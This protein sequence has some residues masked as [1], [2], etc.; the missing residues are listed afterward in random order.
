[1]AT[2]D[3][4]YSNKDDNSTEE[5]QFQKFT[6]ES[7][8]KDGTDT[9]FTSFP[10]PS[11]DSFEE[12]ADLLSGEKKGPPSFWTWEYYQ[13]LFDVDTNQVLQRILWSMIPRPGYMQRCIKSR[14]DLYGPF[15]I[16]A[17]LVFTIAISGNIADYLRSEGMKK[18]IWRYDFH[19]VSF[20]A[21]AIYTYAWFVPLAIW[22]LLWYRSSRTS[23]SLMQIICVYGYSLSIYIPLSILW[24]ININWLQ[25]SLVLIGSVSSGIVLLLTF[26]PTVKSDEKKKGW[27]CNHWGNIHSS[28]C[29]SS[30]IHVLR[31]ENLWKEEQCLTYFFHGTTHKSDLNNIPVSASVNTARI[32][33]NDTR[34]LPKV[35]S[36]VIPDPSKLVASSNVFKD[37]LKN[38]PTAPT[39]LQKVSATSVPQQALASNPE[40]DS[41]APNLQQ[42]SAKKVTNKFSEV[43]KNPK[44]LDKNVKRGVKSKSNKQ[45]SYNST[46]A[47]ENLNT[48]V[49]KQSNVTNEIKITKS[50]KNLASIKQLVASS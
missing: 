2:S 12:E 41:A 42:V 46:L 10:I 26:L 23:Y 43:S 9:H 7:E 11:P 49:K 44:L 22:G 39:T 1:M 19:K 14:P 6:D 21:T 13:S 20:A 35:R 38:N 25:W 50:A 27:L 31:D 37:K 40:Q 5:L 45:N 24:L 4:V 30:W 28:H 36:E 34:S 3:F 47:N 33:T 8:N 15:W 16:C 18:D 32:D 48:T 29:L 17:T